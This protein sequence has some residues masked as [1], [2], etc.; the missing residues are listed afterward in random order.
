MSRRAREWVGAVFAALI[1]SSAVYAIIT[2]TLTIGAV[3]LAGLAL[4]Q[5]GQ[6]LPDQG[7]G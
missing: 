2:G 3:G 5:L 1:I 7:G 4:R 6:P